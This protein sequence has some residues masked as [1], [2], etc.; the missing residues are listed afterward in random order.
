MPPSLPK[1]PIEAAREAVEAALALPRPLVITAP[2]GSGKSTCLPPWIA[3]ACGGPVLVV[4]PRRVACRA[5]ALFLAR[6][7]GERLGQYVGYRVRFDD[8]S[9]PDTQVCFVTPG[10]ALNLL[11]ADTRG[12]GGGARMSDYAALMID[13]F[14]ER[15][16]EIDLLVALARRPGGPRLLACSATLAAEQLGAELDASLVEA[17]GRSFPV[18]IEYLGADPP[19]RR[20]LDTRVADAVEAALATSEGE[21]LVFLP[22]KGEIEACATRLAQRGCELPIIPVHGGLQPE[23][24]VEAFAETGTRRV[25][26]ATNVAESSLTLP[27]VRT[28]IDSGLARMRMHRGGHSTLSLGVIARDSMD[29]RAGRAGRVAAGRCLRLWSRTFIPRETTAPELERIELDDLVLRAADCGL[30]GPAF[31]DAAWINPP[32]RFALDAA[33]A[34][35]AKVGAIDQQAR[36]LELGRGLARLPVSATRARM[37]LAA[38]P[39]LAGTAADLVALLEYRRS[40]WLPAQSAQV[41]AARAEL[42]AQLSPSQRDEL[43]AALL[44]LRCGEPRIHGLHRAGLAEVRRLANSLRQLIGAPALA[45]RPTAELPAPGELARFVLERVPELAFVRRARAKRD[46]HR[47]GR[48]GEPWANGEVELAL[49]EAV[50]PGL[51]PDAGDPPPKAGL[52]LDREWLGEGRSAQGRGRMLLPCSFAELDAAGLGELELSDAKLEIRRGVVRGVEAVVERRFAG[53]CLAKRTQPLSGG[54][55]RATLASMILEGRKL[56][57][58]SAGLRERV[59]DELHVWALLSQAANGPLAGRVVALPE[60]PSADVYL[61]D[62]LA[63]LGLEQASELELLADEDLCPVLDTLAAP[64]VAL[65]ERDWSPDAL[66]RDFPRVWSERGARYSCAVDLGRG[67]VTLEPVDARARKHGEPKAALVPRYRGFAVV[68]SISRP[69]VAWCCA[70][71]HELG[72]VAGWSCRCSGSDRLAREPTNARARPSC[73]RV[74]DRAN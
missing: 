19:S 45:P 61:C 40:L 71:E 54:A 28:V 52:M 66:A 72:C 34:R 32:P 17:E 6:N 60:P 63:Q 7:R 50:V 58:L 20:D 33:R 4:E 49:R 57:P 10:V 5:L 65:G 38:P 3:Q 27:G 68:Y 44:A 51:D 74:K 39:A 73:C 69:A 29:Q 2:T 9:G 62:R 16:W 36:V 1:L 56:P 48:G 14:H 47:P 12:S 59:R 30:D 15:S 53:V 25:F 23:R 35:L 64:I 11:A 22:G 67:R 26:L 37:L 24:L 42:A 8:R 18:E 41:D 70:A 55:L 13:E 31:D 43:H 21:I 46:A